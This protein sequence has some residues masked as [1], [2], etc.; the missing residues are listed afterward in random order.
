MY[1]RSAEPLADEDATGFAEALAK[2]KTQSKAKGQNKVAQWRPPILQ[3]LLDEVSVPER[4][5]HLDAPGGGHFAWEM[6]KAS[7]L[8]QRW[9]EARLNGLG[10]DDAL[11]IKWIRLAVV[12]DPRS[13]QT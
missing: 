8:N 10:G 9:A 5:D 2:A 4:P 11:V 3:V 6:K 12:N 13:R 1:G 7:K